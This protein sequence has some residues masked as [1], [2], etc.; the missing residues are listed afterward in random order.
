MPFNLLSLAIIEAIIRHA[1]GLSLPLLEIAILSYIVLYLFKPNICVLGAQ[2]FYAISFIILIGMWF[3]IP[4]H[5]NFYS[6]GYVTIPLK[7]IIIPYIVHYFSASKQTSLEI[8]IC[9]IMLF[10][11]FFMVD[12]NPI[13]PIQAV[14]KNEFCHYLLSFFGLLSLGFLDKNNKYSWKAVIFTVTFVVVVVSMTLY[15]RQ[16]MVSIIFGIVF[17]NIR[18]KFVNI[19]VVFVTLFGSYFFLMYIV[20]NF[21]SDYMQRKFNFLLFPAD[22]IMTQA[23]THRAQNLIWGLEEFIK[24]PYFGYGLGSFFQNSPT[25]KVAHNTYLAITYE[26]GLLGLFALVLVCLSNFSAL[27]KLIR[28]QKN[29]ANSLSATFIFAILVQAAFMDIM[30]KYSILILLTVPLLAR[31][32][33]RY[34]V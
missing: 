31:H 28:S 33:L 22:Y 34:R 21:L 14:N 5:G 26:L 8:N 11:T 30:A 13:A 9:M 16:F 7:I 20:G 18:L 3:C 27:H 17:A 24:S 2:N 19:S 4:F 1:A 23:D 12:G 32:Y 15:S 6:T 25:G 10:L 29:F